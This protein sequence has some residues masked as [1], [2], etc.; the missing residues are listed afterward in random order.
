MKVKIFSVRADKTFIELVKLEAVQ[1]P[2]K[3]TGAKSATN[4]PR[5]EERAGCPSDSADSAIAPTNRPP[6]PP[7]NPEVSMPHL[8]PS[9]HENL[10]G[11]VMYN[12]DTHRSSTRNTFH[13]IVRK[14]AHFVWLR[15]MNRFEP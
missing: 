13:M 8:T 9:L 2:S 7:V 10:I 4:L 15:R 14:T 3:K 11:K 6:R 12:S 5:P 1:K